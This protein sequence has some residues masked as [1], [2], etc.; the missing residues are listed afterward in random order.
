MP[1]VRYHELDK[2]WGL[3]EIFLF[4]DVV[5]CAVTIGRRITLGGVR[6]EIQDGCQCHGCNMK[7]NN[8]DGKYLRHVNVELQ[9]FLIKCWISVSTVWNSTQYAGDKIR[10]S[11]IE[12]T[13]ISILG[14]MTLYHWKI[15][16]THHRLPSKLGTRQNG[17]TNEALRVKYRSRVVSC[18]DGI[19]WVRSWMTSGI[20]CTKDE[21]D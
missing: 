1:N 16:N 8:P 7:W 14:D 2:L 12:W 9:I 21:L 15:F 6:G 5:Q 13:S 17:W 20:S 3:I 18:K 4:G 11:P 10:Y 19:D